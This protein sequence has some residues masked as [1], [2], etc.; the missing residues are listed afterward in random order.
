M[1]KDFVE[2]INEIANEVNP[3]GTFYHGGDSDAY[4]SDVK[5]PFPQI[6]LQPFTISR[7]EKN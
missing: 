3:Q 2:I 5:N 1:Y 7:P 6:H 4:I